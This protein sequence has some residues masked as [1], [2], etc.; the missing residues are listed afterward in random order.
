MDSFLSRYL[1]AAKTLCHLV[2]SSIAVL[3]IVSHANSLEDHFV[4]T[5]AIF[6]TNLLILYCS[7]YPQSKNATGYMII[8]LAQG[9]TIILVN[10]T[11]DP[12]LKPPSG[13]L[14]NDLIVEFFNPTLDDVDATV[15]SLSVICWTI[16]FACFVFNLSV[17]R[18]LSTEPELRIFNE[19]DIKSG[20]KK[21]SLLVKNS[22]K[23]REK[24]LI[25]TVV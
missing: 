5:A 6:A 16:V 18:F 21:I 2:V 23:G 15:F 20:L 4:W 17:D 19:E 24:P 9:L 11:S 22:I 10:Q 14:D 25:K 12:K 7:Y 1:L 3:M 8:W 13:L